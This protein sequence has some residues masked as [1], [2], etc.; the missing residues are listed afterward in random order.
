MSNQ[1]KPHSLFTEFD[2]SLFQSGKHFRLYEKFGAHLLT[3]D[4]QEGVYFAVFAPMA[5]R[6]QVVGSFNDWQGQDYSLFVRWDSSGIW[7]GFIPGVQ[8]GDLYKYQIFPKVGNQ[9]LYKTDPFEYYEEEAPKTASIVWT[10]EHKWKDKKWLKDRHKHNNLEAPFSIYEVHSTSWKMHPN[11]DLYTYDELAEHLVPY[12]KDMGFTH[13][14][15][16]PVMEH[17]FGGSWGYQVNGFFAPTSRQGEPQAFMRLIDAFHKEG[18][19]VILDWVP[20][21][22]PSDGHGLANFDGSCVYEHPDPQKGYHPDWKSHI[23]NY[24]RAEVRSFLISSALFWLDQFHIDGLRVDAV[25][26]ILHLDYSRKDGEWTPNQYGGNYYLEAIDFIKDFN[27]AVYQNYPDV[28]TIAEE[29]TAFPMVTHPIHL[30]GLGFGMKWMMGWMNDTLEYFKTDP[31]FRRYEQGKLTFNMFYAYSENY[32]LPLSHDEVVHGKAPLIYKMPGDEWQKFA[33]LRLLFGYMFMH[34]GN[35]LLFMGDEFGQTKEWNY[36][37][38]LQW[39]LLQYP[40]HVSLQMLV[41]NLNKIFTHEKSIYEQQYHPNGFEWIDFSDEVQSVIV[42]LIK[43][44]TNTVRVIVICN[45]TPETRDN[46][47]IGVSE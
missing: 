37:E 31:F 24:T 44:K 16:L 45:F 4:G 29:S 10:L 23:F 27:M 46:Y 40:L 1:V 19:S 34:P 42:F 7:E 12:V 33:N 28:Q 13:V 25:A 5:E 8:L 39:H 15:F 17:P 47:R 2:V 30:G 18:I 21:H 6:V 32:V 35:K 14:E 22:F 43:G 20:S 26:S 38:E 3:H 41:K 11:G 36:Q 9:I